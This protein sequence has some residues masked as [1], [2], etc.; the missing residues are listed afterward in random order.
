MMLTGAVVPKVWSFEIS[1]AAM[2]VPLAGP[3]TVGQ[4]VRSIGGPLPGLSAVTGL[5]N[6][7][8]YPTATFG[9]CDGTIVGEVGSVLY[10]G[11]P[12]T[13]LTLFDYQAEAEGCA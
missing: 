7:V 10:G 6:P 5:T 12:P 9:P 2:A 4:C 1:G 8:V 3:P 13:L 11:N